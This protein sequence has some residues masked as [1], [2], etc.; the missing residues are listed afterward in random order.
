MKR[1]AYYTKHGAGI[2]PFKGSRDYFNA[3]MN[4]RT[5]PPPIKECRKEHMSLTAAKYAACERYYALQD[6]V[7]R[8]EQLRKGA[9]NLMR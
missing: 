8:V 5:D 7:R 2:E 4:G 1:E 6:Q 9:E 3:V